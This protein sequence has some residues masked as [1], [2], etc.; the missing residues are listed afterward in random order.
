MGGA[1][2]PLTPPLV[3]PLVETHYNGQFIILLTYL[4][5]IEEYMT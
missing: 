5:S 4:S 2:A 1:S 3:A